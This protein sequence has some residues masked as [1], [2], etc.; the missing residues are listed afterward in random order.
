MG[1]QDETKKQMELKSVLIVQKP[2]DFLS[3]CTSS[4]LKYYQLARTCMYVS[5][6]MVLIAYG[7]QIS[8]SLL[9]ALK[10]FGNG[11]VSVCLFIKHMVYPGG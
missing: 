2:N 7:S 1:Q 5:I 10:T 3:I 6:I 11:P 9:E 8:L 4:I